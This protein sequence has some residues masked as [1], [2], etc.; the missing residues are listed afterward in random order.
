MAGDVATAERHGAAALDYHQRTGNR[1]KLEGIRA[2]LAGM[3]LNVRQFERVIEPSRRALSYFEQIGHERWISSICSNLAEAY[4]ELGQV[5]EALSHAQRVL[6]LENP[7]SRPYALY[8]L[9]LIHQRQGRA[10]YAAASFEDGLHVARRNGDAYIE[11]FLQRNLG[12]LLRQE[13]RAEAA[14]A[15][16]DAA[17]DLFR[18]MNLSDEIARTEAE[19]LMPVAVATIDGPP[20]R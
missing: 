8:T 15:A 9:G 19:L 10:D 2:D 14:A 11:A 13:G 18:R 4:L 12:R 20:R 5:D 16:L 6:Q 3:Y 17:L 1:V 7:R